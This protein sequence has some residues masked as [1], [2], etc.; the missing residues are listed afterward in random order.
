MR[1]AIVAI[2]AALSACGGSI[3][4][5]GG[6]CTVTLSGAQ[7]GTS[8]CTAPATAVYA[9]S[10]AR[11]GIS[12]SGTSS[13]QPSIAVSWAGNVHT[14]TFTQTDAGAQ[15][16]ITVT[17]GSSYWAVSA[18]GGANTGTYALQITSA[19]SLGTVSGGQAW[20]VHGTLTA[21]APAVP[22]SGAS[23]TVNV[24]VTF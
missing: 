5:G 11:S 12:L 20:S 19:T 17:S 15:A 3:D 7:T 9:S 13:G 1:V 24:Q 16:G 14:G 6:S 21:T 10:N 2:C 18:G 23:G 4:L 8:S 22:G